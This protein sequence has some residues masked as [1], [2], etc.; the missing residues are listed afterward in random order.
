MTGRSRH[1]KARLKPDR[2]A[3][4][5]S[6][7]PR[8]V[9]RTGTGTVRSDSPQAA[10]TRSQSP[11][12]PP[13]ARVVALE[14][15]LAVEHAGV[16]ADAA[17]EQT[18][19]QTPL[20]AR[21]RALAFELIYGVL[22]HRGLLD[23]RLAQV[24]DRPL[25]R[26]PPRVRT[27]LRLGLYQILLLDRIPT[28]AAVNESVALVKTTGEKRRDWSG[29][30]NA[31][32]RGV[33]RLPAPAWP[34]PAA[35]PVTSLAVRYSCPEWM[36]RRWIAQRGV[37]GAE[38]TCRLTLTIPLLTV[39]VNTLRTTRDMVYETI[40][41]EGCAARPTTYSPVGI[42][43][44]RSG[45]L[46]GWE[47]FERGLLYIEDEAAQLIPLV[48]DPKP[49]E[50]VLDACAAPGGKAT[51]L[52]ALMGNQGEVVAL[53]RQR[54][55]LRLLEENCR[56]LGV[57]IVRPVLADVAT[58]PVE[59][60][61]ARAR[62]SNAWADTPFDR[63]LVDAP[64]SGLGIL[65]RHPEGKWQKTVATILQ[66]QSLQLAIL[67]RVSRLLRPGGV[68]VYST[69]S[70]EPEETEQVIAQFCRDHK[71]FRRE[72]VGPWLPPTSAPFQT[73]E[74]ALC[75]AP[76]PPLSD[77]MDAFYAARLRKADA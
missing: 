36:V 7:K 24:A 11:R 26:L 15:L 23:W 20:D 68:L 38:A 27:A 69:C 25:D 33:V 46:A 60:K 35:D 47:P 8:R 49:G 62:E 51:H 44:D 67:H 55:R 75:T 16:F 9:A 17:L 28:S 64:C 70:T 77:S 65:R 31:V 50:R 76:A 48:L 4:G 3:A 37:P 71:D 41:A 21:D 43:V 56:R 12:I 52:A 10:R 39:R 6:P 40:Q 2:K 30:V 63:I 74:G 53:D 5:G 61:E 22:R 29:F 72:G 19:Q 73:A 45:P 32:L 14:V 18:C 42:V 57:E 34:D 66:H 54:M 59:P 13:S 58:L 1:P